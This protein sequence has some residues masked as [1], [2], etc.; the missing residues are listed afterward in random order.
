MV[1][2]KNIL[3]ETSNSAVH[4]RNMFH[5]MFNGSEKITLDEH[6]FHTLNFTLRNSIWEIQ[7]RMA[8]NIDPISHFWIQFHFSLHLLMTCSNFLL[9]NHHFGA[10]TANW[11]RGGTS[12]KRITLED[13]SQI[14]MVISSTWNMDEEGGTDWTV[15]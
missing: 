10:A 5:M 1:S 3:R 2:K 9:F 12:E 15:N 14:S 6:N 7:F 11:E 4:F 8:R 13:S